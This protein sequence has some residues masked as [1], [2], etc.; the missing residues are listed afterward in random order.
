MPTAEAAPSTA[1]VA[2]GRISRTAGS[3]SRSA[4]PQLLAIARG[5]IAARRQFHRIA[6]LSY[7]ATV[8]LILE[9]RA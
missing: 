9:T 8:G 4:H 2:V 1:L 3:H 6:T 5:L 7:A